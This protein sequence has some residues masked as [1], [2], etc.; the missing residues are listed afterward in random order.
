MRA[1]YALL[2]LLCA[3]GCTEPSGQP[4]PIPIEELT[5]ADIHDAYR[6]GHYTSEALVAAYLNRMD[7]LNPRI[8][9]VSFRNAMALEDARALDS[10]FAETGVL[11]PLHGIPI[12]IKDNINTAGMPTTAGARALQDYV[13]TSD[14]F[15]VQRLRDAGAILIAKTNMAEW[16][17]SARHTKSSTIGTTRNPY[18]LNRVPAGSSGGT[19]AAVAANLATAG[20]GTDTGN[21]IRG[22]SSHTALVG[23]RTT[24]GMASRDGI[25]PLYLRN[26]VVGPMCRTVEDATRLMQAMAGPDPADT[27]TAYGAGRVETDYLRYLDTAGLQGA[28]I[29]VLRVLSDDAPYSGIKRLFEQSLSDMT[30]LGATVVDSVAVPDFNELRRGQ[31]CNTFRADVEEF[32]RVYAP[33]E[34]VHTLDDIIRKGTLSD[35]AHDR[36]HDARRVATDTDRPCGDAYTDPRRVAFREA[37]ER[38]MDSLQLD[39][40]VFPTW[41]HPP[42]LINNPHGGYRGDNSQI[43]SPHT[44]QP[45][46]TVPMGFTDLGLPAGVQFLGRMYAEPT[47]VKLCYAY[48]Q[49]T[50][51]RH[52]PVVR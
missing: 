1:F 13:P 45:G 25:V 11:R 10:E 39:A 9:A 14:A 28:R 27:L 26:D 6:A 33:D 31:W 30:R 38:T 37:I 34:G 15:V 32:L 12:L 5:I 40:L 50:H 43:I 2:L 18:N 48:E 21:S 44:G 36:L 3:A 7:S 17:F 8:N 35:F 24:L 47:L 19:A 22:P 46:F 42:A 20:L 52:P 4:R 41:N 49:G 23:F 16:A 51:H 29:G